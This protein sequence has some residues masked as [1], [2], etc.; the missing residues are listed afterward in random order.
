V[1]LTS[2]TPEAYFHGALGVALPLEGTHAWVF[3]DRVLL[4]SP[5]DAY[6]AALLAHVMAHE[7]GHVLQGIIRHSESGILKAHWS[8]TDCARMVSF[9][10]MFTREDAILIHHGLEE[11]RARLISGGPGGVQT[12]RSDEISARRERS[13]PAP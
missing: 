6:I 13:M 5:D 7:I 3:Y 4:A 1:M 2:L 12:T 9:P 8:G 11:R 10:L